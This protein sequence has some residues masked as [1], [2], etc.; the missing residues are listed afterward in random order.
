MGFVKLY[1]DILM[2]SIWDEDTE[3]RLLWITLLALADKNGYVRGTAAALARSARLPEDKVRHGLDVLQQPDPSSRTPDNDGRRLEA[4]PGGYLVLNYPQ[5]RARRDAGERQAYMR[6]YMRNRRALEQAVNTTSTDGN[7]VSRRE[8]IA[9]AEAKADAEVQASP[10]APGG[11]GLPTDWGKKLLDWW[12]QLATVNDLS[13]VRSLGEARRRMARKRLLEWQ[14]EENGIRGVLADIA[15]EVPACPFLRGQ[16]RRG[17][18]KLSFDSLIERQRMWRKIIEGGFREAAGNQ[19][20]SVD[21]MM[22]E[23]AKEQEGDADGH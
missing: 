2:S 19:A 6:D 11:D 16:T 4:V 23:W 14:K 3:T 20:Q 22:R 15:R 10:P 18:W 12:N 9:E 17:T 5:Y 7:S 21:D 1:G 8:P 13:K